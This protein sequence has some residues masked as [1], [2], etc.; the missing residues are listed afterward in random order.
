L[1]FSCDSLLYELW[2]QNC[3]CCISW[4][5]LHV[6]GLVE[7]VFIEREYICYYQQWN[8]FHGIER[9][10]KKMRWHFRSFSEH[11]ISLWLIFFTLFLLRFVFPLTEPSPLLSPGRRFSPYLS[12]SPSFQPYSLICRHFHRS[13]VVFIDLS[14]PT[15][16]LLHHSTQHAVLI[17]YGG[18]HISQIG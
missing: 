3:S 12:H 15:K 14:Y 13:V 5:S 4:V 6:A 1:Y 8:E 17:S 16:S 11:C 2:C 18:S 7:L 9:K 10:G